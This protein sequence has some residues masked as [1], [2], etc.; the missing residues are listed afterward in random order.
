MVPPYL[1]QQRGEEQAAGSRSSVCLL[2]ELCALQS[3]G[4]EVAVDPAKGWRAEGKIE[5]KAQRTDYV[6]GC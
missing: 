2:D 3:G 5:T 1:L 6:I 4:R